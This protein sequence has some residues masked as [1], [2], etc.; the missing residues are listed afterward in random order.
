MVREAEKMGLLVW[1][2]IPV[3]WTI[4]YEN[5][6]TYRNAENQLT[7]MITRDKNRAAVILWSIANE[8]PVSD[9]RNKFLGRLAEK[10]RSLDNS[11]LVTAALDTHSGDEGENVIDDPLGGYVDVIGINNY[12]GWYYE[13]PESCGEIKWR[14]TYDKPMMMSEYGAGALQ[15]YHGKAE[16]RWTEEY[17]VAVYE[18]N[19]EMLKG[20]EFLAG[21]SP[22]ILMDFRSA[23]RHLKKIQKD[24]NRKGLISEQGV[25]KKAFYVLQEYYMED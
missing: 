1:S 11:R 23:R 7:E 5:E 3:Y 12:C 20:I 14:N 4:D 17:Q 21:A 13:K 9:A 19:I 25:R 10:T 24:F 2:E 6:E 18:S 16:D 8:T 22:W 15:G